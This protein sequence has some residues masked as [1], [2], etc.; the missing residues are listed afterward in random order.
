MTT[1][2]FRTFLPLLLAALGACSENVGPEG[3]AMTEAE[4]RALVKGLYGEDTAVMDLPEVDVAQLDTPIPLEGSSACSGG[5]TLALAGTATIS[6]NEEQASAVATFDATVTM[7]DCAFVSEGIAFTLS[8]EGLGFTGSW[9]VTAETARGEV[10]VAGPFAW[11][12][13]DRA[14]TCQLDNTIVTAGPITE[15]EPAEETITGTVCEL[16][17]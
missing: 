6:A 9:S 1:T 7:A 5:G 17:I 16:A 14:G 4:A 8:S 12:I 2:R 10:R 13:G 15:D 3:D 11:A